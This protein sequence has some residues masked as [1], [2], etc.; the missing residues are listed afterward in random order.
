MN[1]RYLSAASFEWC[2]I[3]VGFVVMFAVLP[4]A[5]ANDDVTRLS[6]IELLIHHG[7]LSSSRY[8]LVMPIVS[9]PLLLIGELVKTPAWWAE[10]FNVVA[11]A[12]GA[13]V[14]WRLLRPT[15]DARSMRLVLLVLVYA[16]FLT[17]RLRDYNAEL[18]T[19]TLVTV[20]I[21]TLVVGRRRR[22]GWL[23]LIIATVNTPA[24]LLGLAALCVA[25]G[26]RTKR[27]RYLAPVLIAVGLVMLEAWV[28]RGGPFV[29]GYADDHGYRT[30]LPYSGKPGF[31]YPFLFGVAS[32][33]LSFGR[34]L[35]FF[36]PGLLL[37]LSRDDRKRLGLHERTVGLM[38][39]FT[40]GLILVYAKWWA[41]YG[42]A[43]WGPRFFAFAALP[44]SILL[45]ARLRDRVRS[46]GA[47]AVTIGLLTLSAWVGLTGAIASGST[48][49]TCVNNNFALES[50]CW[51]T[52]EFSGLGHPLVD[53]AGLSWS[54]AVIGVLCA[55]VYVYLAAPAATEIAQAG[56]RA[57]SRAVS[58]LPNWRI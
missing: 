36:M 6:D 11:V 7:G 1:R 52:P 23:A 58:S 9:S 35:V 49:D 48:I 53:F 5:L 27:L 14:V 38:I 24:T 29:T 55:I 8:S 40:I 17:N 32:I 3:A 54:T 51:Y 56:A 20:G 31:S 43:S 34:G 46:T 45:G 57:C 50:L 16:S 28:R 19:A 22:L 2:L 33:L 21:V 42:G 44:A 10:R 12:S 15:V 37:W 30:V 47:A 4:H 25:E 41:W 18:L 26:L 13:L 39:V